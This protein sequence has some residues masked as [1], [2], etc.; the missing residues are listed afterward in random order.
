IVRAV[1]DIPRYLNPERGFATNILYGPATFDPA[2][3]AEH[4]KLRKLTD[5]ARAKMNALRQELPGGFD[6]GSAIGS[7]IDAINAKFAAL[8]E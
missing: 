7:G 6:D 8:R 4:D 2:Q 1:G 3:L 5:G